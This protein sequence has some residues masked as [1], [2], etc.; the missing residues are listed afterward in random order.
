MDNKFDNTTPETNTTPDSNA[1][2]NPEQGTVYTDPNADASYTYGTPVEPPKMET[3]PEAKGPEPS[4]ERPSQSTTDSAAA[5]YTYGSVNQSAAPN[6]QAGKQADPGY[7]QPQTDYSQSTSGYQQTNYQNQNNYNPNQYNT[8]NSYG[9]SGQYNNMDGMDATP[10]SMGEW[11][12]T[13][14]AGFIPCAGLILYLIWAFGKTGN[15]NRRNFCRAYLIIELAAVVLSIILVIFI[16]FLG[17]GMGN[18]YYY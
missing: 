8:Q 11:L 15:I 17:I 4:A 5:G 10:L 3:E 7:S 14:L 6:P 18:Y 9:T 13:V 1:T 2:P 12:L 16:T